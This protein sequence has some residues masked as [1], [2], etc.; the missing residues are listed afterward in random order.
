MTKD[1]EKIYQIISKMLDNP[2]EYEIYHTATAYTELEHYI[3]QERMLAIGWCHAD[4][5]TTLD[6]GG[7]PRILEV[8]DI[9][10]RAI[11]DLS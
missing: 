7:D 6:N 10:E 11:K 8:P 2:D 4:A 1:R 5:C 9:L 3:E